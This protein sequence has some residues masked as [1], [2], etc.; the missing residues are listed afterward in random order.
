M[1]LHWLNFNERVFPSDSSLI[2]VNVLH[3]VSLSQTDIQIGL[4]KEIR[5]IHQ[6]VGC[7]RSRFTW[8]NW[9]QTCWVCWLLSGATQSLQHQIVLLGII[10]VRPVVEKPQTMPVMCPQSNNA[11]CIVCRLHKEVKPN[12]SHANTAYNSSC[13]LDLIT[14]IL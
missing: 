9:P 6:R 7:G 2:E 1:C 11:W 12:I 13:E 5:T 10:Y 4:R 3:I 8:P 14:S